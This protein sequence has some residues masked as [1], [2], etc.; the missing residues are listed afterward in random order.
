[1]SS[2]AGVGAVCV[3]LVARSAFSLG[4]GTAPLPALVERAAEFGYPALA[5]T[6]RDNLYGMVEFRRE[7]ERVGVRPIAGAE[8]TGLD[9][10]TPRAV[11]LVRTMSGYSNLCKILTRRMLD[12]AFDLAAALIELHDGLHLLTDDEGLAR[13]LHPHLPA[14]RLWLLLADPP[15]RADDGRRLAAL[16]R[17]L[18]R[19]LVASPDVV[20]LEEADR[21]I[22]RLL[23]AIR[24]RELV[25][26][27]ERLMS[28]AG[29]GLPRPHEIVERFRDFPGALV[30][31]RLIRE[32]CADFELSLG[33]PIFP[34][35][36]L[37]PGETAYSWLFHLCWRGCGRATA[38]A[39][40]TPCAGWPGSSR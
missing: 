14:H 16:G 18:N 3:P 33:R 20:Y 26:R 19:P 31:N 6:D 10:A 4:R 29:S 12:G 40:P 17:E 15:R 30:A 36:P 32:E 9:P 11:A 28:P 24:E 39:A 21:P 7:A 8:I 34:K 22:H 25:S 5:L 2:R 23:G 38:A 13:A 27:A 1:M 37:P 35:C